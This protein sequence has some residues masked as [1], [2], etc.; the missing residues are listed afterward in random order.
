[1]FKID[2]I[3]NVSSQ[4]VPLTPF[5]TNFYEILHTL[6]SSYAATTL[7]IMKRN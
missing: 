7:K 3:E 4:G 5:W 2:N 1:M 6:F